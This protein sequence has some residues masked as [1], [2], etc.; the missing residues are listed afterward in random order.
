MHKRELGYTVE[1]DQ[2]GPALAYPVDRSQF[3]L[4]A[5]AITRAVIALAGKRA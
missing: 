2:V 4:A 1:G 3:Q 5:A